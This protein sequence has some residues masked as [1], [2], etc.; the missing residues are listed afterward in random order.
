MIL[1]FLETAA[2]EPLETSI[3]MLTL[4]RDLADGTGSEL[5]A[6]A[7][8]E[9]GAAVAD[10]LGEYGVEAVHHVADDRLTPYAPAAWGQALADF[11]D[12]HR[13]EAVVAPTWA[14]TSWPRSVPDATTASGR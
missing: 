3:Q 12:D 9:E 10:H 13:P 2:G 4:A 14:S 5:A 11:L 7:V 8:G 6:V 1:G